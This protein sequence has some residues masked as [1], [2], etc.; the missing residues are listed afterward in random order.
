MDAATLIGQLAVAIASAALA[1]ATTYWL[2]L[3]AARK[4]SHHAIRMENY[5]KLLEALREL[6]EA[7]HALQIVRNYEA[8]KDKKPERTFLSLAA[9]AGIILGAQ[10]MTNSMVELERNAESGRYR[11]DLSAWRKTNELLCEKIQLQSVTNLSQYGAQARDASLRLKL[12]RS[13]A[14]ET[15]EM[16]DLTVNLAAIGFAV[17]DDSVESKKKLADL[18]EKLN[19][20][21]K[22]MY[23]QVEAEIA[24]TL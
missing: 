8:K 3:R 18:L 1:S 16:A 10:A 20:Q 7:F 19:P 15:R 9:V 22:A 17:G 21:A 24:D 2:S 23:E 13:K 6:M 11:S 4:Q 12:I 14:I 5:P